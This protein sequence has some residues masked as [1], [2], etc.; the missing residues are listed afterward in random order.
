MSNIKKYKLHLIVLFSLIII[1]LAFFA[2]NIDDFF[3]SDDF[4]WLHLT[5]NSEKPLIDYF[6]ANYYGE[7]GIGGSYR[8][9]FNVI[10]KLNYEIWGL[11]GIGY[12]LFSQMFSYLGLVV[13]LNPAFTALMPTL[14]AMLLAVILIRRV[15]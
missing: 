4:D 10:F 7:Q 1:N 8:P 2:L 9:M 14:L 12:H 5:A 6:S 15:Y 11:I 13:K 3:L